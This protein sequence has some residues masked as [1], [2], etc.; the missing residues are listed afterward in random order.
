MNRLIVFFIFLISFSLYATEKPVVAVFYFKINANI[1]EFD[2]LSEAICEMLITDLSQSEEITVVEREK[3]EKILKEQK[4]SIS[5]FTDVTNAVKVGRLINVDRIVIGSLTVIE[6]KFRLDARLLDVETGKV[7]AAEKS[8]CS[9]KDYIFDMVDETALRIIRKIS[10]EP[11]A[12]I[13]S[14]PRMDV[15]FLL[16]S[17]GSMADEI[18]TVKKKIEEIAKEISYG[19]PKPDVRFGVVTYRDRGDAYVTRKYKLTRNLNEVLT[20]LSL[21]TAS[22]GGDYEESLNEALKVALYDMNWNEDR[23]T[24]KILFLIADAPPHMDYGE[25]F[26]YKDAIL[27]AS[28][29]GISINSIGCS[30]LDERGE[31]IFREISKE[32]NAS[33]NYLTYKHTIIAESGEKK[34]IL[35]EGKEIYVVESTFAEELEDKDWEE[36]VA[37]VTR[38]PE[39]KTKK[40][41][42]DEMESMVATAKKSEKKN[43]LGAL[44]AGGIKSAAEKIG[45]RYETRKIFEYVV[46]SEGKIFNI[47]TEEPS[48][49]KKLDEALKHNKQIW[50]GGAVKV[51]EKNPAGFSFEKGSVIVVDSPPKMS[52]KEVSEISKNPEYHKKHGLMTPNRWMI[53]AKPIKKK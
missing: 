32:T 9:S 3:L 17:T 22:G 50:I 14:G 45:V 39:I 31:K 43:N 44:I 6:T 37:S 41:F 30:G 24:S 48:S 33:F 10:G 38:K 11:P 28:K 49:V 2:Y 18:E 7:I 29:S 27:E 26:T 13:V 19:N 23:K 52:Q 1:T 46:E 21:T 25:E 40:T 35:E 34:E 42:S 5:D 47:S 53:L 51:D 15:L 36:G 4:L 8:Q 20:N 12:Q 16:D